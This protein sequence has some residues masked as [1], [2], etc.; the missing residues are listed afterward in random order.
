VE[1]LKNKVIVENS[2]LHFEL[3]NTTNVN[4]TN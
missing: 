1:D 3:K 2:T 4:G